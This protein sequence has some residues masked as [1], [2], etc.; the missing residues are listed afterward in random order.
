MLTDK[1]KKIVYQPKRIK[2]IVD[3][4]VKVT[5]ESESQ[6]ETWLQDF[7]S[8]FDL[9]EDGVRQVVAELMR[10][11]QTE[12]DRTIPE[13]PTPLLEQQDW[14]TRLMCERVDDLLGQECGPM[15]L[16]SAAQTALAYAVEQ[17]GGVETPEE[18]DN[19]D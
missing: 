10:A 1:S 8:R 7:F 19:G 16:L 3:V 9:D 5:E 13:K 12:I 4:P 18:T 2:G 17:V 6:A 14:A 11:E 15:I